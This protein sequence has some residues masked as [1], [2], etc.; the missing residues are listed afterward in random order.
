MTDWADAAANTAI[1]RG[2][3]DWNFDL[4]RR[5]AAA[6]RVAFLRGR[7]AGLREALGLA[8]RLEIDQLVIALAAQ[9]DQLEAGN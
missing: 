9:A 7:I 8:G 5:I 2:M 6:V 4:E 3:D 1:A